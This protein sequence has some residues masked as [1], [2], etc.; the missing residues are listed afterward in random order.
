MLAPEQISSAR[1]MVCC[2]LAVA[3]ASAV[4]STLR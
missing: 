3:T 4:Y 2:A 1:L